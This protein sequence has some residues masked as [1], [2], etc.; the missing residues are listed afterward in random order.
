MSYYVGESDLLAAPDRARRR[1]AE[2]SSD[3]ARSASGEIRKVASSTFRASTEPGPSYGIG[4]RAVS[5]V[6]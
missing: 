6:D 1:F 5:E 2:T 3:C 4:D